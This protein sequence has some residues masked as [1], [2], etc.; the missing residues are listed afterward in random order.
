M[1]VR[2]LMLALLTAGWLRVRNVADPAYRDRSSAAG[3]EAAQ[4]VRRLSMLL[5]NVLTAD[6]QADF[7]PL[8]V[9]LSSPEWVRSG[10]SQRSR[11][12]AFDIRAAVD[13]SRVEAWAQPLGLDGGSDGMLRG[14][15][16]GEAARAVLLYM[17]ASVGQRSASNEIRDSNAWR[18]L[19]S[20][21]PGFGRSASEFV[22]ALEAIIAAGA[23]PDRERG[24]AAIRAEYAAELEW[25]ITPEGWRIVEGKSVNVRRVE[26]PDAGI[27]SARAA[28]GQGFD[29]RTLPSAI[30]DIGRL[31]GRVPQAPS[32]PDLDLGDANRSEGE[33]PAPA[34]APEPEP[35]PRK[36]KKSRA[37]L[38]IGG[39]VTAAGVLVAL[40]KRGR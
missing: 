2:A 21:A 4:T 6:M 32:T 19:E 18:A 20:A 16:G 31:A 25:L 40:I 36:K 23:V 39:V 38:V 1:N 29:A 5:G 33:A 8:L 9:L 12:V 14:I 35:A 15:P 34:P 22:G 27:E 30:R 26:V 28:I 13:P 3:V 7:A 11:M 37:G 24:A 10:V 17:Q